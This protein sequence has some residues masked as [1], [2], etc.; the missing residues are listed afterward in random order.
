MIADD[1]LP[2]LPQAL[3]QG[4]AGHLLASCVAEYNALKAFDRETFTLDADPAKA[5]RAEQ[6][7][8]GWRRW[9]E[10]ADLLLTRLVG[11]DA[12][13]TADRK[14]LEAMV[15]HARHIVRRDVELLRR[16]LKQAEAGEVI[17]REEARR[18]LGLRDRR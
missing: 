9:A 7:R 13:A 6:L 5:A 11:A 14:Q 17:T 16:R 8:E 15:F 12:I 4:A 10:E 2:P 18:A 3:P 1:I